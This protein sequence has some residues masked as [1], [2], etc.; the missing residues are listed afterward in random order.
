MERIEV[1]AGR[2]WWSRDYLNILA[3]LPGG[4]HLR[5]P[6]EPEDDD[7]GLEPND[8]DLIVTLVRNISESLANTDDVDLQERYREIRSQY[9]ALLVLFELITPTRPASGPIQ[10]L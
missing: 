2:R 3:D 6:I 8:A 10:P 7:G 5:A 4:E 1:Y 9:A